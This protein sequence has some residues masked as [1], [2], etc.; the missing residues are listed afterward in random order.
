MIRVY[1]SRLNALIT[2]GKKRNKMMATNPKKTQSIKPG[3]FRLLN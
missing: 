2:I 1:F 3:D